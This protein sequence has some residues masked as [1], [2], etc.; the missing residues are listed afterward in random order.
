VVSPIPRIL[1]WSRRHRAVVA[2]GA[3]CLAALSAL[4]ARRLSFDTD[5]LSLLPRDGRVI[6][7]F[8][9]FVEHFGSFDQ[10]YVVFTAPEGHS[11]AEYETE[12]GTWIARLRS[13]PEI[14][15]V[16]GGM[17][18]RSGNV[19][20]LGDRQL[21]LL[22][23]DRLEEAL[24]RL[25]GDGMRE[26]IA[27]R[28]ELLAVPSPEIAEMVRRDPLGLYDLLRE[29]AGSSQSGLNFGLAS[30]AFVTPG[31]R[32]RLVLALPAHAPYNT[33]FSH[34][35]FAALDR[36]RGDIES[37]RDRSADDE[38]LPPMQVE[39]AGGHRIAVETEALVRRES[40]LNSA[41]SLALI[42]PLLFLV[43]R[44]IWLVAVGPIPSS[45]SLVIVLG[46]LGLAGATLSAAATASAA[47]LFGLGIDGVVL[48]YVA[49]TLALRDG[50]DPAAAVD[51]LTGPASSMLLG[52]ATTAATFYG[53]AVVDFPSLQQLGLLIGHSMLL[54]G[55]FTLF[56]VPAFLPRRAPSWRVR[57]LMLPKLA[58]WIARRRVLI[59]GASGL[60]TVALGA[61]AVNL[62]INPTLDRLRS[63]TAGAVFLD[64]IGAEFGLPADVYVLMQRG[65][66]LDELLAA[67]ERMADGIRTRHPGMRIQAATTL[68]PSAA[69]QARRAEAIRRAAL[70]PA[71]IEAALAAAGREEGFREDTF[72]PFRERLPQL[73]AH[74]E[75][76][77]PEGYDTHGLAD[78]IG[79]FVARTA[80]GW[81][82]ASYV[83]PAAESQITSVQAAASGAGA[84][85]TGLPLVNRELADRFLPQFARGLAIGTAVVLIMILIALRNWR[86]SLLSLAPVAMGLI[87]AAGLLA[88]ARVEL[89]VFALFAVVTFVGIGVDYGVHLVH[90][91]RER[92]DARRAVEELAP[93]ILVAAAITLLG[94]GTLVASSYPPLR[95]IGLV[96]IVAV[97]TLAAASVLVLPA[98]LVT[99]E[100]PAA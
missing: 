17:A 98:M 41:G 64:R 44:S 38:P 35:L 19:G 77:T 7:A 67:N 88:L 60:A 6:P 20:W 87:W 62:R 22:R 90:R 46:L 82:L 71:R 43:F 8:R 53:L 96:S 16:D 11:I 26:A 86:L 94:Y 40:I 10:L 25:Q 9:D 69:T 73:L 99:P 21:L 57:P 32:R 75:R 78:L 93:V 81:L 65:A 59:L 83:F 29:Q 13:L 51:G 34:T 33:D 76:L 72:A 70:S 23:D 97:L 56:L 52:M 36:L 79:R 2:S 89:D 92:G 31:G 85:L 47:L 5:V 80:D 15:R 12:V 49:Y 61:A 24:R 14:A 48:L 45:I 58:L 50:A 55:V 28:R 37:A 27:S 4:G 18:D 30:G 39:F 91:Y 95:S 66:D 68:L 42:L 3:L 84:T 54:C 1:S 63:V 74:G 100:R